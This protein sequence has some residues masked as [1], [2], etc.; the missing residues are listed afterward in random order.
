M[1]MYVLNKGLFRSQPIDLICEEVGMRIGRM[2]WLHVP[3]HCPGQI[4]ARIDDVLL[5]AD[6]VLETTSPHQAPESLTLSTGLSHYLESLNHL[7]AHSQGIRLT[8]GGHEGPILDLNRRIGEIAQVHKARLL[9]ILE[10]T[11]QACTID[12]ISRR[13]FPAVEGYH[14]LLAVE[15]A[16]AHVEYLHQRGFLTVENFAEIERRNGVPIRYIRTEADE[17]DRLETAFKV[18]SQVAVGYERPLN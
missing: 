11:E 13:L 4:I 1:A 18:F 14:Q 15:E 5:S 10:F 7:R 6:H 17:F 8:L 12:D 3:G 16:G 2:Q 9:E